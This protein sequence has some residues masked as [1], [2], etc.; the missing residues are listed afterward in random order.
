MEI[1]SRPQALGTVICKYCGELIDSVD[2]EKV[3]TYYS[4]CKQEQC[5]N[6]DSEFQRGELKLE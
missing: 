3:M 5:L 2:T 1:P 4:N 6:Q